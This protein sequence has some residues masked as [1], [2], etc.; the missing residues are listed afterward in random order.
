DGNEPVG[1]RSLI[2]PGPPGLYQLN[3]ERKHIDGTDEKV[4]RW[5]YGR[6]DRNKQNKVILLVGE[7]GAGKTAMINTMVNYLLG[8][9]FE[10][11]KFYQITEE[12][13]P[14]AQSQSLTSEITVYEVF[15]EE[16]PISPSL[17]LQDTETLKDSIEKERLLSIWAGYSQMRIFTI[18]MPCVS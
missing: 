16:N 14:E 10:D 9:K 8:V 13:K 3:T 6:R 11:I 12:E 4:R 1:K 18:L 5:T 15:V 2:N 17:T 7:T